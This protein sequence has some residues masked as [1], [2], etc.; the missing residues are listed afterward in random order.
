MNLRV[1]A[2]SQ[3][4][5]PGLCLHTWWTEQVLQKR[6]S[7][8][9]CSCS[10]SEQRCTTTLAATFTSAF[11]SDCCIL[12]TAALRRLWSL[13]SPDATPATS[14]QFL[15]TVVGQ[16]FYHGS[17]FLPVVLTCSWSKILREG[18]ADRIGTGLEQVIYRDG[19]G[20]LGWYSLKV[21]RLS[22]F[23]QCLQV[24]YRRVLEDTARLFLEV[25]SNATESNRHK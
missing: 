1:S 3:S 16:E 11:D 17:Q 21:R 4:I 18:L 5:C 13:D 6:M 10:C 23:Y 7:C 8:Q 15:P 2:L 9:Q 19:L 20:M 22:G 12:E 14:V 25:Y 24:S